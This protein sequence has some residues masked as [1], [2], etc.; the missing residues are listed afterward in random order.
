MRS[1]QVPSTARAAHGAALRPMSVVGGAQA[2]QGQGLRRFSDSAAADGEFGS[3]KSMT[4]F[5]A[6]RKCCSAST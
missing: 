3:N 6:A 5:G 4:F 1:A 2:A